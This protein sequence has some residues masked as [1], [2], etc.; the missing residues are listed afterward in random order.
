[1]G[2]VNTQIRAAAESAERQ[3]RLITLDEIESPIVRAGASYWRR[4][5]G[6]RRYPARAD[7]S[8]A[9]IRT[10]L[11]HT[12]LVKVMDGGADYDF[13]IVGDA[14]VTAY[15]FS[16]HGRLLS[17]LDGF[18]P[19]HGEVL[20]RLYDRP[21]RRREPFALRGWL[22][23]GDAHK[24]YIFSESVFMPLGPDDDHVDHVLNFS[25]YTPHDGRD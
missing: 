21:V 19:G 20:K 16:M 13:R 9:D 8:P 2:N 5:R 1:M 7:M 23:R 4:L 12:I 17:E 22:E 3:S 24:Q 6:E 10:I 14:H 18:A 11:R 25:V 15:G